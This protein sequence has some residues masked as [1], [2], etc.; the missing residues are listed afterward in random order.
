MSFTKVSNCIT[1]VN[2][3]YISTFLPNKKGSLA[4]EQYKFKNTNSIF[5]LNTI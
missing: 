4:M 5:V 3:N 2:N 1:W